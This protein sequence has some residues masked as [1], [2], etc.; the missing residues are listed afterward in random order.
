MVLPGKF[1]ISTR[2]SESSLTKRLCF[3]I[4]HGIIG[5][6]KLNI[7]ISKGKQQMVGNFKSKRE[8]GFTIIEVLIVLA[9]AGLIMLIVFLAV[10]ALQRTSRNTQRKN[11][12]AGYLAAVTE[13]S[14]NNNG[15]TPVT[16]DLTALNALANTSANMTKPAAVVTGAQTTAVALDTIQLVTGAKCDTATVGNTIAG[17]ARAF[18]VR[19]TLETSGTGTQAQCSES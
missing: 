9:I 12:V 7:L 13:W 17:S 16:A 1:K 6:Y 15:K 8:E 10:P 5:V 18:A 2:L 4:I 3:K 11:D 19:Y 14:N